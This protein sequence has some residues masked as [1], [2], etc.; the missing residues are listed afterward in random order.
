MASSLQYEASDERMDMDPIVSNTGS[1]RIY[2]YVVGTDESPFSVKIMPH[3]T[4]EE[5]KEEINT[6]I[7]LVARKDV[8]KLK[9]YCI[10]LPDDDDLI[11][12]V[13]EALAGKPP[14]EKSTKKLGVVF[15]SGPR[16]DLIHILIQIPQSG[17]FLRDDQTNQPSANPAPP[18][19]SKLMIRP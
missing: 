5:L 14:S 1:W 13:D 16:E 15:P 18:Q 3:A 10:N 2:C 11:K 7:E 4:V 17:E 12:N 8:H 6:K 9:L 19:I